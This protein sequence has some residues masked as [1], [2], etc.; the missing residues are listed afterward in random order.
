MLQN[1]L[2]RTKMRIEHSV[3]AQQESNLVVGGQEAG[4]IEKKTDTHLILNK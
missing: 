2:K 1:I 3:R 4:V